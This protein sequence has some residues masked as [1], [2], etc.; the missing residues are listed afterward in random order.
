MPSSPPSPL[1]PSFSSSYTF[2][3]LCSLL[4]IAILLFSDAAALTPAR[5]LD[6]LLRNLALHSYHSPHP[7]KTG[8]LLPLHLPTASLSATAA[9]FRSGSLR[10]YG[11]AILE[12]SV[13][14][15][16]AVEPYAERLLVVRQRLDAALSPSSY[17]PAPG[18]RLLSPVLGLLFYNP[19]GAELRIASI[20]RPISIDFSGS[21]GE[22][23]S[24]A[25]PVCAFWDL[26]SNVRLSEPA[27]GGKVCLGYKEGHYGLLVEEGVKGRAPAVKRWKMAVGGAVGG[28]V[29]VVLL[30]LLLT[31]MV[32][33]KKRRVK[34]AEMER[35]AYE[36]EAL[37]VSMVGHVR[38]PVA[39][40]VR[41]LPVPETKYAP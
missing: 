36:E 9:R 30:L 40:G 27:A 26:A 19:D 5:R 2:M 38:A 33:K 28:V 12:F 15:G 35:R 29:G 37:Q 23:P 13:G 11:A 4:L 16:T 6:S 24:G 14:P 41:T 18:Y 22:A 34:M 31:A 21:A 20:T 10:R 7:P 1:L 17:Y 3:A 32:K 8:H 25:A 39:A